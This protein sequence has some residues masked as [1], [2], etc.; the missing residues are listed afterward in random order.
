MQKWEY[1]SDHNQVDIQVCQKYIGLF[2]ICT[3]IKGVRRGGN[4]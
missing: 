4:V 2:E 1:R 3:V